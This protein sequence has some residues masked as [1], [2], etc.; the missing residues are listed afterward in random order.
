MQA[1]S[2]GEIDAFTCLVHT[3]LPS[4]RATGGSLV[5]LTSAALLRHSPGDV[6]STAPKA[7]ISA[8]VRAVA[9][10]EGRHGVRA[11]EVAVG[12]IDAGMAR[13]IDFPEGWEERARA[14]IPLCRP[15][16]VDEVAQVVAMLAA[17]S[18]VT[19]QQVAVDGGYSV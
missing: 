1:S 8:I 2:V 17:T 5:A 4:L 13:V 11:N 19:G 18:Y 12:W 9:R 3:V 15:G 14:N 7:A 16:R 6:L 10:E